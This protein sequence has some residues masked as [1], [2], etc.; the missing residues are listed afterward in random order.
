MKADSLQRLR[1][2]REA[3]DFDPLPDSI[4]D[5]TINGRFDRIAALHP[6]RLAVVDRNS[7]LTYAEL[8]RKSNQLA[9][10]IVNLCGAPSRPVALVLPQGV[11]AVIA[12]LGALK[13]GKFYVPLDCAAPKDWLKEVLAELQPAIILSDANYLAPARSVSPA[14]VPVMDAIAADHTVSENLMPAGSVVADDIAYIFYTSG[15][16]GSPKGVFDTHRN[17]LHNIMRY[18]NSLA[19][20]IDDRLSLLQSPSFSGTVSSLFCALL[21]GACAYPVDL[22]RESMRTLAA[23]LDEQAIS[24]YHSVPTIF[25][26]IAA[27]SRNFPSV[28]IVRLEGD[29]ALKRDLELFRQH[30]PAAAALVNGLGTTETGL[31]CQF[32]MDRNTQLTGDMLPVGYPSQDMQVQVV[33]NQGGKLPYGEI[34]EIAVTSRY[35]AA[36]YWQRANLTAEVFQQSAVDP[37]VRTYRT[38]DLGRLAE[39]GLLECLGR[40]DSRV[41]FRG[42]WILPALIE[43]AVT[44]LPG[45]EE[46]AVAVDGVIGNERLIAYIEEEGPKPLEADGLRIQ[47]S[48]KLPSYALPSRFVSVSEIPVTPNGK[49]D[50]AALSRLDQSRPKRSTPYVSPYSPL[51]QRLVELWC[52]VLEIDQVGVRDNFFE[53]GGDSLRTVQMLTSVELMIEREISPDFLFANN[54]IEKLADALLSSEDFEAPPRI[55]NATGQQQPL[56]FLHGDYFS[57][58]VYVRELARHLGSEQPVVPIGPCGLAGEPVPPSYRDMAEIHLKQ[59]CAIQSKGPYWLGGQCNG[60][61]V[62]YEIAQILAER[63]EIVDRL[64][65]IHASASNLRFQRLRDNLALRTLSVLDGGIGDKV[66]LWTR[67]HLDWI[68]RH[69]AQPYLGISF[70][71]LARKVASL[72]SGLLRAGDAVAQAAAHQ[73]IAT[74]RANL[75]SVYQRIDRLY[76][77][78]PLAGP[79]AL[80]WPEDCAKESLADVKPWWQ[81]ICPQIEFQEIPGDNTSCLTKHVDTLAQAIKVA[82]SK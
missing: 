9:N 7:R 33:D 64:V 63:E 18:T 76:F 54:T 70:T 14:G 46:A 50:R 41:R 81:G 61:L 80:I 74:N 25:R 73:C 66:F 56:F 58:G 39:D 35:L 43:E 29:R 37:K 30:F 5:A 32:F 38:G 23:W 36:G 19:I 16:T 52:D 79:V 4:T 22:R 78:E 21:N 68:R 45:I 71:Q 60:G 17:V 47:L 28:R 65:L 15:T 11:P 44:S 27:V 1:I 24:I 55:L 77:P 51:H 40:A 13:A 49:L 69:R 57:G 34:G 6:H 8:Q 42:H 26:T 12:I 59:I 72:A 67:R 31:V 62:A 82:L 48:T 20:G 2:R 53:L 3:V 75:R 10:I